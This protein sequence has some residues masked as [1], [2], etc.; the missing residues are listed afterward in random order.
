VEKGGKDRAY[1]G[2]SKGIYLLLHEEVVYHFYSVL[3]SSQ[4]HHSVPVL[5]KISGETG[6]LGDTGET[7]GRRLGAGEAGG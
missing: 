3:A 6:K 2:I 5:E 1:L 7:G 4:V